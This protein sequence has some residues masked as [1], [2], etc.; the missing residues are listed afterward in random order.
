MDWADDVAYCVHDVEDGVQSGDIDLSSLRDPG[1]RRELVALVRGTYAPDASED[2]LDEALGRLLAQPWMPRSFDGSRRSL[3]GLKNGTSQLIGRFCSAVEVATR[4]QHGPG[5]LVRHGADLVLPPEAVHEV[6]V[7]KGV[8][9]RWVMRPRERHPAWERQREVLA[10][11]VALLLD[12][13]PG[14]LGPVFREDWEHASDDAARL[15]VVVDQVASFSDASAVA[16][17]EALRDRGPRTEGRR[18]TGTGTTGPT[19]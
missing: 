4:A 9:A 2:E 18:L 17:W 15:R 14:A 11:L 16:R 5:P 3:A 13:A 6:G 10:E 7:L 8:A 12:Q 19:R 1:H